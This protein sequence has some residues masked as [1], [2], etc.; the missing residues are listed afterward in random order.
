[1]IL[2]K[3]RVGLVNG[4]YATASGVGGITII[5]TYRS[6]SENKLSLVNW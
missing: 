3:P 2:N 1:M 4:L 5:E 6:L